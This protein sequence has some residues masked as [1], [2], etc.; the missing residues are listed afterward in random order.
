MFTRHIKVLTHPDPR[1]NSYP[2]LYPHRY[3]I[4]ICIFL[5]LHLFVSMYI[6][7]YSIYRYFFPSLSLSKQVHACVIKH[8]VCDR[9]IHRPVATSKWIT[10]QLLTELCIVVSSSSLISPS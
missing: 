10:L 8:C 1:I 5:Y 7:V 3:N 2:Y 6:D 9:S 4:Y